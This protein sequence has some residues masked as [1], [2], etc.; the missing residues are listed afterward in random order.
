M[1][2]VFSVFSRKAFVK[3][4]KTA[5]QLDKTEVFRHHNKT[6]FGAVSERF[7]EAVLKTVEPKGSG[8]SNPPC[9]GS[10]VGTPQFRAGRT[11]KNR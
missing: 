10:A 4:D 11:R 9:S 1:A 8:G 5:A 3:I 7:K 6:F 2:Y